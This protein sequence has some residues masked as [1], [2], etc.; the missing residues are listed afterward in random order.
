MQNATKY[1]KKV[2]RLLGR[3]RKAAEG[4]AAADRVEIMVEGI[5]QADATGKQAVAAIAALKEEFVDFNELRVAPPKEIAE[6]IG[7]NYPGAGDKAEMM[8]GVLGTIYN[9]TCGINIDYMERMTKRDL[10]RHLAELGLSPYAVSYL[11]LMGFGGHAVPV[12]PTLVECLEMDGYIHP[13]SDLNDVQGFLER[14]I[15]HK[16]AVACHYE[17]RA[18]VEGSAKKLAKRRQARARAEARARAKAEAQAAAKAKAAKA[19]AKKK[20]KKKKAKAPKK[21]ALAAKKRPK[22]ARR[23]KRAARKAAKKT[24]RKKA[25]RAARKKA[26]TG[27]RKRKA[28]SRSAGSARAKR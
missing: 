26:A 7:H 12:D 6:C 19:A 18:H 25:K 4:A 17:L 22:A 2:R 16:N 27:A 11:T 20:K 15:A 28:A 13:G 10:R 8:S 1:E 9:R 24:A 5:L 21:K 14:I 3:R 23:K